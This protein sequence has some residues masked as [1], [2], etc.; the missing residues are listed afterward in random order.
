MSLRVVWYRL[1]PE[2]PSPSNSTRN[3]GRSIRF[4]RR[5]GIYSPRYTASYFIKHNFNTIHCRNCGN[6]VIRAYSVI[7]P[8]VLL[9]EWSCG[10]HLCY[11]TSRIDIQAVCD[12]Q[13]SC[14]AEDTS[15]SL[16]CKWS[17]VYVYMCKGVQLK[18]ELQHTGKWSD[19]ALPPRC[20]RYRP[21]IFF[22]HLHLIAPL[23][24]QG[25]TNHPFQTC[26]YINF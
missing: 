5:V 6:Q 16:V 23:F 3:T 10:S 11:E 18:S 19:A 7:T 4:L 25:T 17:G 12:L 13:R 21:A 26:Y 20:L 8:A 14:A 24:P 15:G 2:K 1:F 22:P 9:L